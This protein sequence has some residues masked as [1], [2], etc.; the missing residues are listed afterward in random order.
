MGA[1]RPAASAPHAGAPPGPPAPLPA[2]RAPRT[3]ALKLFDT[4]WRAGTA[5]ATAK[6]GGCA[7]IRDCVRTV[8]GARPAPS[9]ASA[10]PT[11]A[12]PLGVAARGGPLAAASTPGAGAA[13]C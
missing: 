1:A 11:A 9:S 4:V 5:T 12:A 3:C 10:A 6:A 7:L 8:P 13:P 2:P